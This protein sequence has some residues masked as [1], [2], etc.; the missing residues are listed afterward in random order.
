M[1]LFRIKSLSLSVHH[2]AVV[3][4]LI[5]RWRQRASNQKRTNTIDCARST[6]A[7]R[8]SPVQP[9]GISAQTISNSDNLWN[10]SSMK[11]RGHEQSIYSLPFSL[12]ACMCAFGNCLLTSLE[13]F[14][15]IASRAVLWCR[16][17]MYI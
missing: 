1:P 7:E 3:S 5:A 17:F 10:I 13:G 6:S 16:R 8:K 9:S 14:L 4:Q 11:C 2:L 12:F 15:H